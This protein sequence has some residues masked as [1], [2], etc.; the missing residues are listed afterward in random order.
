[1]SHIYSA[2]RLLITCVYVHVRKGVRLLNFKCKFVGRTRTKE[3]G[4]VVFVWSS[5]DG[6]GARLLISECKVTTLIS[7]LQK[8][9]QK[10]NGESRVDTIT[11]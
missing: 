11:H 7:F 9:T 8:K 10:V 6:N 4:L 3:I 1:M 5:S 2:Y